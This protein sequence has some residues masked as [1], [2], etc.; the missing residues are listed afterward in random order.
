MG[1]VLFAVR[2]ISWQDAVAFGV[3]YAGILLLLVGG[4]PLAVPSMRRLEAA[5]I[6]WPILFLIALLV[7][8]VPILS[9]LWSEVWTK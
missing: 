2:L 4:A 3:G 1:T 7:P 5:G 9:G 8:L 6:S